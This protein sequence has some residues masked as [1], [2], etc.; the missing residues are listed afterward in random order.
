L[1]LQA[2]YVK[3]K[4]EGDLADRLATIQSVVKLL[5]D[6]IEWSALGEKEWDSLEMFLKVHTTNGDI[7][8]IVNLAMIMIS[9]H[10]KVAP[11]RKAV[12]DE[13]EETIQQFLDSLN[14]EN[15]GFAWDAVESVDHMVRLHLSQLA[16]GNVKDL[17]A[18]LKVDEFSTS[19][20]KVFYR[21]IMKQIITDKLDKLQVGM[22]SSTQCSSPVPGACSASAGTPS[23]SAGT[24]STPFTSPGGHSETDTV[25]KKRKRDRDWTADEKEALMM[26]VCSKEPAYKSLGVTSMEDVKVRDDKKDGRLAR[27]TSNQLMVRT[28]ARTLIPDPCRK[29]NSLFFLFP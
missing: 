16:L 2:T 10:K 27:F 12:E 13:D 25:R 26:F 6:Q 11:L 5:G 17:N 19:N 9:V 22:P 23:T 14:K 21:E 7:Q 4:I 29:R 1:L 8:K 28:K 20:A 24:P 3:R 18:R 15:P